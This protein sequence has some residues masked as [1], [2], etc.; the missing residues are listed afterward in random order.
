MARL[1]MRG[2]RRVPNMP[3]YG[4]MPEYALISPN[5]P[6]HDWI[7]LNAAEYTWKYLNKVFWLCQGSQYDAI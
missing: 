7:L 1:Y 2:L 4:S 6:E 3:D 5:L